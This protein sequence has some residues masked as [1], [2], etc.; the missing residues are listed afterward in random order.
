MVRGPTAP[1][2]S[3]RCIGFGMAVVAVPRPWEKSGLDGFRVWPWCGRWMRPFCLLAG[4]SCPLADSHSDGIRPGR[5]RSRAAA[6]QCL[7]TIIALPFDSGFWGAVVRIREI[8][9]CNSDAIP[10]ERASGLPLFCS[11]L[12]SWGKPRI[13]PLAL[14]ESIACVLSDPLAKCCC[15][16]TSD[17]VTGR[18]IRLPVGNRRSR[19]PPGNRLIRQK[20]PYFLKFLNFSKL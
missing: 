11:Q 10:L 14:R 4:F 7:V 6:H 9:T 3:G 15:G 1:H 2:R 8:P 18:E 5:P 16:G 17:L 19:P 20:I 12:S 13:N